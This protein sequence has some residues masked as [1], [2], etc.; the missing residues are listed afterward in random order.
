MDLR[1]K[2]FWL[3]IYKKWEMGLQRYLLMVVFN[4]GNRQAG[5]IH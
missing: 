1:K 2:M 3:L 5:R 4:G